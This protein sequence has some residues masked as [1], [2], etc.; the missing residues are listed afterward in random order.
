M[1][2]QKGTA[3]NRFVAR[4][5][6]LWAEEPDAEKRWDRLQPLLRELLADPELRARSR[7]WPARAP[8][9]P[10]ENLVFYEDPEFGFVVNGLVK[11]PGTRT[12]IHDHAHNWTL[13]GVLD[14]SETIER[15]ERLDDGTRP[16]Y[17]D[18]RQTGNFR[19]YPGD[20]DLVRP[21][22]I[23]AEESGA[24]RTVAI[25]VRAE[26]PGGFLQGRYD[27]AQKKY[28]QGYGPK[29]VPYPLEGI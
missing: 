2:S 16:E 11:A 13:Y 19:V 10:P 21:G 29:Q 27:P 15:Y 26:K 17:A 14:G 5:R 1:A 23:H 20:V 4:A 18:L 25:I 22:Q 3:L 7:E 9:D 28:S 8:H 24:E 12:P 6:S